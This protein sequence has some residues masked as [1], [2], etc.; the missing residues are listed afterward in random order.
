MNEERVL[1]G[2]KMCNRDSSML[3]Q[4]VQQVSLLSYRPT[5]IRLD[6]FIA[7]KEINPLLTIFDDVLEKSGPEPYLVLADKRDRRANKGRKRLQ[8]LKLA[9]SIGQAN[10]SKTKELDIEKL[11]VA[12]GQHK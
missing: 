2:S 10:V 6:Q 9:E 4:Q 8:A 7:F 3:A 5:D 1:V 12:K 11:Q